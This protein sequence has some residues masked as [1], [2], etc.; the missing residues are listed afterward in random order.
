MARGGTRKLKKH[1]GGWSLFGTCGRRGCTMPANNSNNTNKNKSP[2]PNRTYVKL[3]DSV[4]HCMNDAD[5][6]RGRPLIRHLS[7]ITIVGNNKHE[8]KNSFN[9]IITNIIYATSCQDLF[10]NY[11]SAQLNT[12]FERDSKELYIYKKIIKLVRENIKGRETNEE[13][14]EYF[15]HVAPRI[16]ENDYERKMNIQKANNYIRNMHA[17]NSNPIW[18]E[19]MVGVKKRK[20]D[21][22][23]NLNRL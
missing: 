19:Q 8:I 3:E 17:K 2:I 18:A 15:K 5:Y 6:K 20:D 14:L 23:E 13:K 12:I 16:A 1:V 9:E 4:K 22:E 10:L 21:M 11:C 7:D